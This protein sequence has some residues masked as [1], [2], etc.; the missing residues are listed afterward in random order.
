MKSGYVDAPAGEFFYEMSGSGAGAPLVCIHG[1]P[2]FCGYYLAPLHALGDTL[3]VV[4]YDQAGCGR[5]RRGGP[6][7]LFN[8]EGFVAELEALRSALGAETLH[9]FGH[10][11]GGVVAGEYAL[12]YPERVKS[13]IFGSVSIDIPRWIADSQRL[14]A[15][16]PLMDRMILREGE[17][18]G[19]INTPEYARA[20]A[21]YYRRFVYGFDEKPEIIA[22][23]ER[24]SDM[25]TYTTVWGANELLVNGA[26]KNYSLSPRLPEI[27][28]PTLFVCGR[29]D[30]ATPEAH[31]FFASQCRQ[32]A[33]R[34]FENSAHHP[35]ITD[36]HLFLSTV[37]EFWEAHRG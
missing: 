23:S 22:H 11:F 35:H 37:K 24:E 6:R 26:F 5:A 14:L 32:S 17:R 25:Q 18:T 7:K 12:R 4:L 10:S 21:V 19:T 30:E 2:G 27:T 34:I 33:L 13:I 16:L 20:L 28:C 29:Y 3:P 1:G 36:G 15:Q 9:L 8:V 31:E